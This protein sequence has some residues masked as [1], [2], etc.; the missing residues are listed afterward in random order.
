MQARTLAEL[1][2]YVSMPAPQ[3][4]FLDRY[5]SNV[6]EAIAEV[7]NTVTQLE[8]HVARTESEGAVLPRLVE[9]LRGELSELKDAIQ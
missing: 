7:D 2:R 9:Q 6:H 8:R 4:E 1:I 5:E 3:K